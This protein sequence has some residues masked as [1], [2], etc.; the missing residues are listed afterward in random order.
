MK[1]VYFIGIGGIGMSALARYYN[2]L[3]YFTAGYDRSES[4]LTSQLENEGIEI[5]YQDSVS[6]IPPSIINNKKNTLVVYTPA[7]PS[8]SKELNWFRANKFEMIKRSSALG[9]IASTKN[10]LAIAGTQEKPQYLPC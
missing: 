3:G 7:I 2:N 6:L 8:D 5:H 1:N 4:A 9:H 10:T